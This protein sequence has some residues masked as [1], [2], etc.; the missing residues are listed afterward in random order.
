MK[1]PRLLSLDTAN[2]T[3]RDSLLCQSIRDDMNRELASPI[4]KYS[5]ALDC[6][7]S[8][9]EAELLQAFSRQ[10]F[11]HDPGREPHIPHDSQNL[12]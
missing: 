8:R 11:P 2:R 9:P 7:T 3:V 10:I 1:V 4:Y 6:L 12:V 5:E